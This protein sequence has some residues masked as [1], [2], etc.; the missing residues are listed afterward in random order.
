[1]QP[2]YA[3]PIDNI[4][5]NNKNLVIWPIFDPRLPN[6]KIACIQYIAEFIRIRHIAWA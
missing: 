5:S 4:S 2:S 6:F 1:M 3:V